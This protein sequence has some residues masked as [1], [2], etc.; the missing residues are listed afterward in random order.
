M[1]CTAHT[2]SAW[3]PPIY[4]SDNE[5]WVVMQ[6]RD[7]FQRD[8]GML[9]EIYIRSS[10]G[11]LVPLAAVSKF[12]TGV[13]PLTINH[14]GQ[15]PS[16]TISFNLMPGV[17]LGQAVNEVQ[18]LAKSMLPISINTSFQGAAQAF[19]QSLAAWGCC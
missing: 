13:G 18:G 3:F 6:V 14:T 9:S 10:S 16:V 8:P 15:L 2:G 4:T 17:A 19:Q 11:Q 1:P 7:R 12:S 5:Y